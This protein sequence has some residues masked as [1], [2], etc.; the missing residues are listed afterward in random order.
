[1]S[2]R[3][4]TRIVVLSGSVLLGMGLVAA[5]QATS[6]WQ[7]QLLFGVLIGVAAGSFYAPMIAAAS[8]W[9]D[10]HRSLAVALVSA[11]MGVAPL[12]V[13]PSASWLIASHDWR[14]AMLIIGIAVRC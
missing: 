4:G 13:A 10:Q 12:T 11:G 6:L 1:L 5:S 14:T 7:F 2:D 3:F 8:A 9:I